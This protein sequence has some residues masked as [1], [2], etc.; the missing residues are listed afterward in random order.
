MKPAREVADG[1][2]EDEVAAPRLLR[3]LVDVAQLA[4]VD[5]EAAGDRPVEQERLA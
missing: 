1:E 2:P 3:E 4:V 5:V